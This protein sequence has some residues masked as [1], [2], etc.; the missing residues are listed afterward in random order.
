MYVFCHSFCDI[1]KKN[2]MGLFMW[3]LCNYNYF[4]L[5]KQFYPLSK[6]L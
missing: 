1:L 6:R 5:L 2:L 3:I 4:M